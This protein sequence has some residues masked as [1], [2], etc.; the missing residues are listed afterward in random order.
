MHAKQRSGRFQ[1]YRSRYVRKEQKGNSHGYAEQVFVGSLPIDSLS[2]PS[3]LVDK[4]TD[5]ERI[6]VESKVIEPARQTAEAKRIAEEA[7][8]RDPNWRIKEAAALLRAASELPDAGPESLSAVGVAAV[9]YAIASLRAF[10]RPSE[11]VSPVDHPL[12]RVV[13]ALQDASREISEGHHDRAQVENMKE[14][15]ENKLWTEIKSE[16]D[17]LMRALQAAGF[18]KKKG[19]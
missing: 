2:I 15:E 14:T 7:H 1:L 3:E 8:A 18:V 6:Y 11:G 12:K 16:T 19:G 5:A 13:D 9:E 17:E 10:A 4:L